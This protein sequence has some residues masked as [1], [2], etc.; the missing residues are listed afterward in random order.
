MSEEMI[1]PAGKTI[2]KVE[3]WP[4]DVKN[5]ILKILKTYVKKEKITENA[6][7]SM[8]WDDQGQ[9]VDVDYHFDDNGCVEDSCLCFAEL[10]EDGNPTDESWE[11]AKN[12]A[13]I[14][15]DEYHLPVQ[16]V[17]DVKTTAM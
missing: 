16:I 6:Q 1:I 10:Y 11:E 17:I 2:S 9:W 3:E 15:S 8:M 7:V 13:Q 4:R 12:V 5:K 14:L